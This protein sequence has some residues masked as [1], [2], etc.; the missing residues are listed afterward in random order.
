MMEE[1][2]EILKRQIL[3]QEEN[4]KKIE[5]IPYRDSTIYDNKIVLSVEH[6]KLLLSL[7]EKQIEL[8]KM[9]EYNKKSLSEKEYKDLMKVLYPKNKKNN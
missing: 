4:K 8:D 5:S 9:D 7:I 1:L 3:Y 6:A 2:I